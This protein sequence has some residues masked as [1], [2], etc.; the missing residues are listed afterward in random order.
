MWQPTF[1]GTPY[2]ARMSAKLPD[3]DTLRVPARWLYPGDA[4][5]PRWSHRDADD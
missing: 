2:C 5:R 1:A 4:D 3:L